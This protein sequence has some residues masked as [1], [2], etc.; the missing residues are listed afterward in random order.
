MST[1]ETKSIIRHFSPAWYA[2]VMGTGGVANVLYLLGAHSTLLH[3]AAIALWL[4]NTALFLILIGP[5]I[6]RWIYHYDQL[7][8]DLK[9]P[10]LSNFFITMPAGSII[11]GTNFL[12]M[13]KPY[14]D[15]G[16]L[17]GLGIVLWVLGA[18][19]ALIFAVYGMYNLMTAESIGP[20]PINFAWL[21]TPVVNIVVPLL[22]NILVKETAGA[23]PGLAGLINIIDITFY[24]IGLLLFIIMA[25]FVTNRL[26]LHKLPP[27]M[28]A[29]TFW[30]LLGPVGVGTAALLGMA[31]ASKAVGLVLAVDTL[32]FIALVIWGFG[33]WAFALTVAITVK[34]LR[35]GGVPFSLSWWAFIFPLAAYTTATFGVFSLT[36]VSP[37]L[38]YA[39]I[40]TI[41]LVVLW[42]STFLKTLIGT[43]NGR[44]LSPP[45]ARG[46]AK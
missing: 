42:A 10:L 20:D 37:V 24:G 26:I 23:N 33:L 4:L 17:V 32:K 13:G 41:L 30:V 2:S 31:D 27:A 35:T 38:W 46:P 36:G 7:L 43:L 12:T 29:P 3:W 19:L 39:V 28:T 16:F 21:M 25:A 44:L 45:P 34:Y 5:W 15:S 40:L 22:G 8:M 1:G 14:L 11:L 6:A 9:H 18:A